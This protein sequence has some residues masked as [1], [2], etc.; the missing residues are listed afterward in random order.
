MTSKMKR[1]NPAES[2]ADRAMVSNG[3]YL[4]IVSLAWLAF[5]MWKSHEAPTDPNLGKPAVEPPT[6]MNS[7]EGQ[8]WRAIERSY[9]SLDCESG[10][11]VFLVADGV[12]FRAVCKQVRY[13]DRRADVQ[14]MLEN[15]SG[16]RVD[17]CH[18]KGHWFPN[19][20]ANLPPESGVRI[21]TAD[22]PKAM[23][24]AEFVQMDLQ[25]SFNKREELKG[26]S[27]EVGKVVTLSNL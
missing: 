22:C 18:L 20:K 6:G 5:A 27:L 9:G 15:V 19:K 1:K 3:R 23:E 12:R 11:P 25:F 24:P 4:V 2:T 7:D 14:M 10:E 13:M 26:I 21:A 16:K 8:D 17:G